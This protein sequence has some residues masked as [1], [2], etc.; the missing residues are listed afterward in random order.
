MARPAEDLY[1]DDFYAWTRQQAAIIRRLP[2][3]DN[4]FD[5]DRVA[6]E[7][8]DLGKSER[9]AVRSQVRRI[10][11]HFLKLQYSPA[12]TPRR[13]WQAT[14]ADFR[15]EL[16]DKLTGTLR[17]DVRERL[18]ILYAAAR[19]KAV[20]ALEEFGE[21]AVVA[22]IPETCPYGLANIVRDDWYPSP[23]A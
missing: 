5:R 13:D 15:A 18:P 19:R 16:A 17:R 11:E 7:I 3:A 21:A 14:I 6:G 10:L 8:A 9:D 2:V 4:R 12:S 20:L 1:E 22:E 23:P